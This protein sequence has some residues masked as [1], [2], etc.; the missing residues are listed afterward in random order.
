M[1]PI[2]TRLATDGEGEIVKAL[3]GQK[4]PVED[5]V[6]FSTLNPYWLVAVIDGEIV[7]CIQTLPSRP[8]GGL[9]NLHVSASLGWKDHALVVERL[10]LDGCAV[11]AYHGAGLVSGFV[12]DTLASYRKVLERRGA[13]IWDRGAM[14]MR[15]VV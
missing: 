3:L 13:I 7:G 5:W 1:T 14:M 10:V 2:T 12:P 4:K 6:D 8:F 11:L 15:R 9:E